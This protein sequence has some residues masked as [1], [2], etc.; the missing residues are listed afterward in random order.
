[1]GDTK[2]GDEWST[3]LW[4]FDAIDLEFGFT[5]DAAASSD[6]HKVERYFDKDRDG[7]AQPWE[8]EYVWCNPPYS[9]PE[10]WVE[11]AVSE[12][13]AT[14]ALLLP[15]DTSTRWFAM[16]WDAA[17][18]VRFLAPRIKFGGGAGS[19]RW[20]SVLFVFEPEFLKREVMLWE[21]AQYKK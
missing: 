8:D 21:V 11:K 4:L 19:P 18:E 20:G 3:P 15:S 17:S 2:G 9:D 10:P 7:L 13:E 6:N 16:A 14:T 1:M 12:R 5:L